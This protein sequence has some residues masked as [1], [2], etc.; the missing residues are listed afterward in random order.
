M[1][2]ESRILDY[3]K[4]GRLLTPIGALK[5]F[6]CFRLAAR[7]AELRAAGHLIATNTI[8][9]RSGKRIAAYVLL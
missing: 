6:G 9:T 4:S 1:S 8:K 5:L 7:I 3:L 2:Q